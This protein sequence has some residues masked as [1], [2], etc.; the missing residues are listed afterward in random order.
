[1]RLLGIAGLLAAL[2]GCGAQHTTGRAKTLASLPAAC[3][4]AHYWNGSACAARPQVNK[5][6]ATAI[7]AVASFQVDKAIDILGK[8]RK[9][10]PQRYDTLVKINEQLGIAHAY[11][12][13]ER[14]ALRV[15]DTLLALDPGHLL[16]YHLSP[17]VTFVY[18]RA[19]LAAKK[20]Q[21]PTLHISWPRGLKTTSPVPVDVSV[22]A[23]PKGFLARAAIWVR[24]K[25]DPR[26]KRVEVALPKPGKYRRVVLPALGATNPETLQ[27]YVTAFDDHRNEVLRWS[28]AERPREIALD[29]RKPARWYRKW[30]VWAVAGGVVAAGTGTAVYLIGREP[31]AT[32]GGGLD[33]TR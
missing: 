12:K 15:F 29:Y 19:R 31:P 9:Q 2:G 33:I 25:G 3:D 32:V 24:K 17:Q 11:Q 23:D 10:T 28:S 26:F 7:K 16:S 14:A 4:A 13:H 18:E 1:M 6:L 27:L 8:L 20:R 22:V 21:P 5:Q 30:W